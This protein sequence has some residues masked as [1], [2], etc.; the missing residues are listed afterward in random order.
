MMMRKHIKRCFFLT[1]T[2]NRTLIDLWLQKNVDFF[3]LFFSLLLHP[4][5]QSLIFIIFNA[6]ANYQPIAYLCLVSHW[7]PYLIII[8]QMLLSHCKYFY[9]KSYSLL[10][11]FSHKFHWL[12]N[13]NFKD[14]NKFWLFTINTIF[15]LTFKVVRHQL[16]HTKLKWN[17]L[18]LSFFYCL[19]SHYSKKY[20]TK[21]KI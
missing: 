10:I 17:E 5:A 2:T 4:L 7:I 14:F 15:T 19:S 6:L 9:F 3:S 12:H 21:I 1:S 13:I 11:F 20:V 16:W 8:L 18:F